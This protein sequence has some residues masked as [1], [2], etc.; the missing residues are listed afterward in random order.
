MQGSRI[1]KINENLKKE[2]SRYI[3]EEIPTDGI[4]TVKDVDA[5][6]DIKNATVWVSLLGETEENFMEKIKEK[7]R[8]IQAFI[9]KKVTTKNIPILSFRIDHSGE[10]AQNIERILKNV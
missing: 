2:I 10:Y 8:D 3:E 5:S 9:A 1:E 4:I 7:R 6:K